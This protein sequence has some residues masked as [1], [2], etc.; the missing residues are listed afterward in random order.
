M[1]TQGGDRTRSLLALALGRRLEAADRALDETETA[2]RR[3]A[4]GLPPESQHWLASAR[5][6]ILRARAAL[7]GLVGRAESPEPVTS[8]PSHLPGDPV[9]EEVASADEEG[10]ENQTPHPG[11]GNEQR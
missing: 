6:G 2:L 3:L 10:G 5:L 1:G 11:G 4:R 8:L 7:S 9:D